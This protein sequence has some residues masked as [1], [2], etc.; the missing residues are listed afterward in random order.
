MTYCGP[1]GIPLSTFLSWDPHDQAAA[2]AWEAHEARR[3]SGCGTHPD[4]WDEE[5]GG[6]RHAWKARLHMCE[7][8]N[9]LHQV[10]QTQES[11]RPGIRV[12]MVR[13]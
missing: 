9:A 2:L 4:D 6:S 5:Q 10:S 7:G 8:C 11:Q 13:G 12:H 3:C 1:R